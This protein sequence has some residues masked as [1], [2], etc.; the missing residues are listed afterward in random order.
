MFSFISIPWQAIKKIKI[1]KITMSDFTKKWLV[2]LKTVN[3][4][5]ICRP[6]DSDP[7]MFRFLLT[8]TGFVTYFIILT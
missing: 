7:V 4:K 3:R 5:P 6:K 2:V 8:K 1:K